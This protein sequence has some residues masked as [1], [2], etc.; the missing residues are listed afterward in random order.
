MSVVESQLLYAAPVWS[1]S[2][3]SRDK[4]RSNFRRPQRKAALR[5]IR[6][7]RMV[8]DEAAFLLADMSPADL[9]AAERGRI[10][11]R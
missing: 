7:Y 8:S 6:A 10:K 2:V 1:S 9:I 3:N 4:F 11:V 5:V